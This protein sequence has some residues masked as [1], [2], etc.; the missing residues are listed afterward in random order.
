[1]IDRK[2][3][4]LHTA[5]DLFANEGF[6][7]VPTS[8]IAK[9]AE[10]SEGLIFRHFE[11]KQGLLNALI[12]EASEKVNTLFTPILL[13]TDAKMVIQKTI[14]LPF[15]V[16]KNE[17]PFWKLQFKLKW[18]NDYDGSDK[19]EPLIVKLAWAFKVLGYEEPRKEA[20]IL[21]HII[22]SISTGILR[23]S[24]KSQIGLKDFL[25]HKYLK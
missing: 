5:L 24:V 11:N 23:D 19:M 12:Q 3:K 2:K 16:S 13:Q 15:S 10:V 1:M 18:E 4:I 14:E 25:I 21:N 8:K 20:E 22:E 17:Y 6:K 7:S 9:H